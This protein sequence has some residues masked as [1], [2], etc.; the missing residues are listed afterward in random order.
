M[1]T[2][3]APA[4]KTVKTNPLGHLRALAQSSSR[5]SLPHTP[6]PA[7]SK[8]SPDESL[9]IAAL[10][11]LSGAH[12]DRLRGVLVFA[13]IC[14][15]VGKIAENLSISS[16]FP[17]SSLSSYSMASPRS[18]WPKS[19][20]RR[21]HLQLFRLAGHRLRPLPA[22]RSLDT[23]QSASTVRHELW[24]H[25]PRT[26]RLLCPLRRRQQSRD[27]RT[28]RSSRRPGSLRRWGHH[29]RLGTLSRFSS[30]ERAR[31]SP[32]SGTGDFRPVTD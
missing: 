19:R 13:P 18:E 16:Q 14:G 1:R 28:S 9:L 27:S 21:S 31:C 6:L 15:S 12:H 30:W 5:C 24:R 20:G 29:R 23:P 26:D 8:P 10:S 3:Y 11:V 4:W 2:E 17:S 7:S 25:D 32:E 22:F